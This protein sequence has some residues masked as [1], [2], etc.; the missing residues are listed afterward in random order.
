MSVSVT[1]LRKERGW[2][3]AQNVNNE[4][5]NVCNNRREDDRP[6]G[7][8]LD[9]ILHDCLGDNAV[10]LPDGACYDPRGLASWWERSRNNPTTRATFSDADE[11]AVR[12][13]A[14][15]AVRPQSQ[16]VL[17]KELMHA[18]SHGDNAEV[19]RQIAAGADVHANND[20]ALWFASSNGHALVV[21]QLLAAGAD[22]HA[23]ND[24]ALRF[25]SRNGH[26]PVVA[27]LLAAGA[28]VHAFNDCAFRW[29]SSNGHAPVV[30]QLLAAG[31]NA[32]ANNEDALQRA[33]SNGHAPVV[34]QL[35]AAGA[36]IH[37]DNDAE[38]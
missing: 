31:A 29:A 22:V 10:R 6:D 30:A 2:N 26:A 38:L 1:L 37:A 24:G 20:W 36:D 14:G 12:Q 17:D 9:P 4:E 7:C 21:A 11:A 32:H 34:A 15:L 13:L 23:D 8:L 16:D 27:Q 19:A 5:K 33:S 18:A 28:D 25:A 35:L 3:A